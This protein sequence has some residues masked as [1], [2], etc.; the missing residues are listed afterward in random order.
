MPKRPMHSCIYQGHVSHRRFLPVRHDFR[1][2]IFLLYVDLAQLRASD[3][4][5]DLK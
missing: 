4:K 3:L 5:G 1:Y 2:G